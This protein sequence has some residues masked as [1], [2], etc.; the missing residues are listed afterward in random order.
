MDSHTAT[1]HPNERTIDS[2]GFEHIHGVDTGDRSPDGTPEAPQVDRGGI[3]LLIIGSILAVVLIA[4]V[5]LFFFGPWMALVVLIFGGGL[6]VGGNPVIWAS[7]LRSRER[8]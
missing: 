4:G 1:E 8:D 5:V 3:A 2:E 6:A 7:V